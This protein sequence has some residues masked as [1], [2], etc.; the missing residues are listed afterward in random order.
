MKIFAKRTKKNSIGSSSSEKERTENKSDPIVEELLKK[1]PSE[2]NA[3]E[4]RMIKRYQDRREEDGEASEKNNDNTNNN[5]QVNNSTFDGVVDN[6]DKN[7]DQKKG[8][9]STSEKDHDNDDDSNNKSDSSNSSDLESSKGGG[10]IEAVTSPTDATPTAS[11]EDMDDEKTNNNDSGKTGTSTTTS[12][13]TAI[14]SC[15]GPTQ[16]H[17]QVVRALLDQL[18][19]KQKRTLSRKLERQGLSVLD[20]VEKEA[21]E[22]LK[23]DVPSTDKVETKSGNKRGHDKVGDEMDSPSGDKVSTT[24]SNKKR[25]KEVDLSR[26]PPEER[27]RRQEQARLQQEAAERRAKGD[28]IAKPGHKHPLNSQRR[29][30][31]RRKP[32]WKKPSV[33]VKNEHN[34]SGFVMRKHTGGGKV[35]AA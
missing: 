4:R 8:I 23:V 35:A 32:K 18:N 29:R 12:T 5:D 19:S 33:G 11:V 34:S 24:L 31:N 21:K 17:E 14:D 20:E 22:M 6:D 13:R 15:D 16:D 25:K 30:A 9:A 1:D 3:K 26:L 7:V 10:D 2:W 27:L 28:I